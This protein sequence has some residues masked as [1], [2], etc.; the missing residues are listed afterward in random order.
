M[1]NFKIISLMFF[2]LICQSKVMAASMKCEVGGASMEKKYNDSVAML[3]A[4]VLTREDEENITRVLN[5]AVENKCHQAAVVLAGIKI[6]TL[7]DPKNPVGTHKY[8]EIEMSVL[9]LLKEANSLD[10]GWFEMGVFLSMPRGSYYDLLQ[11]KSALSKAKE[12]GDDRAG[13]MLLQ[14]ES[15]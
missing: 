8:K 12:K 5:N 3:D 11:A 7:A 13:P 4:R 15:K 14:L 6:M 2:S 10:E 9:R 1:K